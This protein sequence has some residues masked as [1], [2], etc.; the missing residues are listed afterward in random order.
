MLDIHCHILP[1]VDDGCPDLAES[2]GLAQEMAKVGF[3]QIACSPHYG[4][5]PG[6]DIDFNE[7]ATRLEGLQKALREAEIP[8]EL[9]SN[10][11][12][13]LSPALFER[14]ESGRIMPL[15]GVGKW[16]LVELPWNSIPNVQDVLFR[17]SLKGF[18][19]LLAHPERY[20]YLDRKVAERLVEMGIK[21]QLELGSFVG[22]YG[23]VAE[24]NA[25]H[26]VKSGMSHV[27]GTDL[28]RLKQAKSWLQK[29]LGHLQK[30]YGEEFVT[31]GFSINPRKLI[32]DESADELHGLRIQ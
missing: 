31:T 25:R 12:H 3:R 15:G 16:L 1:G 6:G 19:L 21:F 9:L 10:A 11:E 32:D 27:L 17:L 14:V 29:G 30:K 7:H 4:E 8:I 24:K 28:H 20:T 26:Y 22:V 13:H 5:G 23:R 18:K 2:L